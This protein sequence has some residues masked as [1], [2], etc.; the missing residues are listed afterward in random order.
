VA[1]LLEA[2]GR[3]D[4]AFEELERAQEEK[5]YSLLYIGVDA[6][7]DPLRADPRFARFCRKAFWSRAA[8]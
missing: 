2:L 3:R 6:K 1:L 8:Y 4:E 7:A 5:A